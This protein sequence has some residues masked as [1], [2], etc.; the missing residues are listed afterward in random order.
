[1]KDLVF[2]LQDIKV[3]KLKLHIRIL[4]YV[5]K[6]TNIVA[7]SSVTAFCKPISQICRSGIVF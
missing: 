7:L 6:K 5:R 3:K 2:V 1:M 4:R